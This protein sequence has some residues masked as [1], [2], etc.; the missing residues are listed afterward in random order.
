MKIAGTSLKPLELWRSDVRAADTLDFARSLAATALRAGSGGMVTDAGPR[1]AQPLTLYQRETCPYS[2]LV[3]E[4]LSD[5]DLDALIKPCPEG[6]RVHHAEL[7]E[8]SGDSKI[9]F[10][11]DENSGE[12]LGESRRI[13]EYLFAQYGRGALPWPLRFQKLAEASSR[14]ASAV[15]GTELAYVQPAVRPAQPLE[16]W[17]YEASPYCRIVREKLDALAL[18]YVSHNLA[19]KSPRRREL[20]E[21]HGKLQFPYLVD[22][23]TATRT[24]E[25][26]LIVRHL[27]Q[28]YAPNGLELLGAAAQPHL[29]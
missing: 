27:E 26:A 23:N 8:L 2:R 14:A 24:F 22:P 16:L 12:Q 6:E 13:L 19:R 4:A 17:N 29:M 1:P 10:L 20:L 3:R 7:R 25:S 21:R 9:P 15:R 28:A 5:L 11:V 18:P